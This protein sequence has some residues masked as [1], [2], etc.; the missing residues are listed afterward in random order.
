MK[1]KNF[2]SLLCPM[3]AKPKKRKSLI[4]YLVF[5]SIES[6]NNL[7]S[8]IHRSYISY[9]PAHEAELV[10]IL[11]LLPD[12]VCNLLPEK[13]GATRWQLTGSKTPLS[14]DILIYK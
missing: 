3:M 4:W 14:E 9:L 13:Y 12:S 10:I 11:T 1:L 6:K 7:L 5:Y 2:E 8:L